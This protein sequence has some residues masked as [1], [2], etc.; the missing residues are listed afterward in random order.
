L[1]NS[2]KNYA[3]HNPE[4]YPSTRE[5]TVTMETGIMGIVLNSDHPLP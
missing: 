1:W 3:T 2:W 5:V 4:G